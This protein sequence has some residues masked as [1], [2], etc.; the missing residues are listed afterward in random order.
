MDETQPTSNAPP[1]LVCLIKHDSG[2]PTG[3][4]AGI[5]EHPSKARS[6]TAWKALERSIA[7]SRG[8]FNSETNGLPS[9]WGDATYPDVEWPTRSA[10]WISHMGG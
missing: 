8:A 1:L 2:W 10:Q 3:A 9:S 5:V 4:A 6:P 7:G